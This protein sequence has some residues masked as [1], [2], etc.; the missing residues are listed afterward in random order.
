MAVCRRPSNTLPPAADPLN[1]DLR[2][3]VRLHIQAGSSELLLADALRLAHRAATAHVP[4]ELRISA[5]MQH[6]FQNFRGLLSEAD[7]AVQAAGN[8]LASHRPPHS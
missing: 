7:M 4:V 8:F 3:L 5:H 1:A 6:V 2:G